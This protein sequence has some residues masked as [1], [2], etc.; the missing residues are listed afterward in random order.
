MKVLIKK[1]SDLLSDKLSLEQRGILITLLL[2]KEDDPKL[3]LAKF[4]AKVKYTKIK[5]D[6]VYLQDNN[7][8]KWN[9][10][11]AAV[12]SLEQESANPLV[13]EV[14]D[15]MN[16][17]YG[18]KFDWMSAATTGGLRNRLL[19]YSVEE[20]KAVIANR[21]EEWKDDSAMKKHLTPHTIFRPSKFVKYLEDVKSTGVGMGIVEADKFGLEDGDEI[22]P[23]NVNCF[24]PREIYK[25][26]TYQ[27]DMRGEQK[28]S[29]VSS[30]EYGVTITRLIQRQQNSLRFGSVKESIYIYQKR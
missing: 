16:N 4:K 21:Y 28:G 13:K 15:F 10:Y 29:G 8:I 7:F 9:G 5:K 2:V 14:M 30:T 19:E 20:I 1:T 6:L 26:K 17:L 24:L 27:C 11:A 22:T 3:T 18:R 12:K 25:I 23:D